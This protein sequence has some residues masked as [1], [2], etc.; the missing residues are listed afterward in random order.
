VWVRVSVIEI[1]ASPSE[2]CDSV[3]ALVPEVEDQHVG[4][5]NTTKT[6]LCWTPFRGE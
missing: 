5:D 2:D 3:S 6:K 4:G 1:H